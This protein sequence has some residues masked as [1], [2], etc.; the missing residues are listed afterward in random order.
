MAVKE[1]GKKPITQ[2]RD[3]VTPAQDGQKPAKSVAFKQDD[4]AVAENSESSSAAPGPEPL[5]KKGVT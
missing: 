3:P 1:N 2:E 4:A 5:K